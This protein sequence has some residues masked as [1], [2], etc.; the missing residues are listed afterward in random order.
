MC[1]ASEERPADYYYTLKQ[2]D[3]PAITLKSLTVNNIDYYVT[4]ASVKRWNIQGSKR[5]GDRVTGAHD[6]L[7]LVGSEG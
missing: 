3:N 1:R 6:L 4:M 5:T 2:K 7:M